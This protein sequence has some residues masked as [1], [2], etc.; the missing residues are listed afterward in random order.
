MTL[1]WR[2]KTNWLKKRMEVEDAEMRKRM[3]CY[4]VTKHKKRRKKKV[5][6]KQNIAKQYEEDLRMGAIPE[7]IMV[8]QYLSS[9]GVK[10][11]FQK[12]IFIN[13]RK[14]YIADF[15][16]PDSRIILEVDGCQHYTDDG[17]L[18]D[19]IR[20][21]KIEALGYRVR[22]VSN[23]IIRNDFDF[24]KKQLRKWFIA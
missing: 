4:K 18:K 9:I 6:K 13:P 5:N 14:F 21:A 22:R 20:D 2:G 8:E 11:K 24:F 3:G 19:K 16:F 17:L 12:S 1:E 7:E 10:H 23:D 15:Y